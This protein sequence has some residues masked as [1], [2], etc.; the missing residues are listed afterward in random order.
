VIETRERFERAWLDLRESTTQPK[1][2]ALLA[3]SQALPYSQRTML[4]VAIDCSRL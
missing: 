2:L 1:V 4:T 3:N